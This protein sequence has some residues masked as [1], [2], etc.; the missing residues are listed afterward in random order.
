MIR[1]I[2]VFAGACVAWVSIASSAVAAPPADVTQRIRQF[3]QGL[4]PAVRV[5]GEAPKLTSLKDRMAELH[6]PGVSVAVIHKGRIDWA[7]GYGVTQTGGAP[8]TEKSLFQAASISK[9]VFAMAVLHLVDQGKLKL[10]SDVNEYLKSWKLPQNPLTATEK[11]TLR[12][13]LSH[14][15]GL[16][17]HGFRGYAAKEPV[18]NTVQILDGAPPAN[19]D[20]IRV[21]IVPG[22]QHRY[23]G[24]GYTLAQLVVADVTGT[25]IPQYLRDTVLAPLGMQLST[26]E[27]PLP[28]NRKGEVALPYRGDGT[29]VSGGPHTYPEMAAA[30][31]WTTPS[32][33][34]R[35]ALGVRDALAGKSKV[36][37]APTA[38]AMLTPVIGNHGIG[39]VIGGGT[40][41]KYFTHNGGNEGYR[42]AL[43]MYEDGEGAVV[44]TS[45]DNGGGL[46]YEVMRTI[47]HEYEWPDFAPPTR[48]LGAVKPDDLDKLVGA[49]RL[50]DG[51]VYLVRKRE[52]VLVGQLVGDPPVAV[53]PSSD[54]E[55]FARDVDAVATFTR[56][57]D[58]GITALR[59][60][61][62]G[63]ERPGNRL[64][65]AESRKVLASAARADQRVK[66][67]KVDPRA[68]P[69]LRELLAQLAEG[70]P[71][72]WRM[73]PQFADA[74]R[75]QLPGLQPMF[76]NFGAVKRVEFQRVSENG[77]D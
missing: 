71:D 35:Y 12:R 44:M 59:H 64:D 47:A 53:F 52:G 54:L 21:D 18:P 61:I 3:E 33:L 39:P 58:G 6:V 57:A 51:A 48:K 63:W 77:S 30:G 69:T 49:Y 40:T 41:R 75:Q 19:S 42:C 2:Q 68:E 55:L 46:M 29:P 22:S 31:L 11:V 70:R 65:E 1:R 37:S 14:S 45:G 4:Q 16:T 23:S 66:D 36:I 7:R 20:P 32:D 56:G 15:A 60:R 38:R 67:Q 8:L 62:W 50:Q 26:F 76:S 28:E 10:D 43:V 74:I 9:P 27:Q 25:P 24:G 72:Y 17:V 5:A 13:L 34:A 73:D